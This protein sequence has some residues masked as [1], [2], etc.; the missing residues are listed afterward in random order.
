QLPR[1]FILTASL[2]VDGCT[3]A[4][5][6]CQN[7]LSFF[8]GEPLQPYTVA[9]RAGLFHVCS[10]PDSRPPRHFNLTGALR[11]R[12]LY[13][14]VSYVPERSSIASRGGSLYF[15]IVAHQVEFFT[16]VHLVRS[17]LDIST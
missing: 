17:T 10:L 1:D 7:F 3:T 6:V 13:H 16:F 15:H 2:V 8:L 9:P 14:R 12:W 11:R 4:C 5:Q